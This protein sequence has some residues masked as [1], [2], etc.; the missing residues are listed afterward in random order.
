MRSVIANRLGIKCVGLLDAPPML[1]FLHLQSI[2]KELS[3]DAN[4][5]ADADRL[6]QPRVGKFIG[7]VAANTEKGCDV[8]HGVCSA[9]RRPFSLV[10]IKQSLLLI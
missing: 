4:H 7:R 10:L 5:V 6:E 1:L 2:F 8:V 3:E 9:L